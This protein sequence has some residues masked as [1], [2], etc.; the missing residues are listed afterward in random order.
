[1]VVGHIGLVGQYNVH[2]FSGT[3]PSPSIS[4]LTT[5]F[6]SKARNERPCTPARKCIS[7]EPLRMNSMSSEASFKASEW[8][9]GNRQELERIHCAYEGSIVN[10]QLCVNK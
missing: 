2:A 10:E 9:E 8:Y 5:L 1:M 3:F 6:R 7:G 4:Q